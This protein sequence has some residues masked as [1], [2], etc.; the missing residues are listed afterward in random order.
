[1]P[2]FM[3]VLSINWDPKIKFGDLV[4]I[5]VDADM[6]AAGLKAIG[7]GDEIIRKRFAN[8]WWGVD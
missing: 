8:R 2:Q 6:R 4:K 5:M 7:E 3:P 1:M